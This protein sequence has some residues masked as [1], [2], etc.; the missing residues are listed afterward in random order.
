MRISD[1]S[2]DVCSSD[3]LVD[4]RGG[5]RRGI[6]VRRLQHHGQR[7][8]VLGSQ[9]RGNASEDASAKDASADERRRKDTL[10]SVLHGPAIP[11]SCRG[12]VVRPAPLCA[13]DASY[14]PTASPTIP[15]HSSPPPF[16]PAHH[17]TTA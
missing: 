4:R 12:P 6:E 2:S 3:L 5:V 7:Q 9:R 11:P 14:L 17:H 15:T 13:F 8:A 1:W 10:K 16:T